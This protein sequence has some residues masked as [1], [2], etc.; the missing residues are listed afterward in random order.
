MESGA[1][2][3]TRIMQMQIV[4][5]LRLGERRRAS[6]LLLDFGYRSHSLRADDFVD[7]I[8]YC[9]RSPDPLVC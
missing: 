8:N 6:N 4:N 7:I 2:S 5:A 3:A 9:A 1:A